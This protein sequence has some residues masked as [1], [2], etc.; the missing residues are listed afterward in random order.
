MPPLVCGVYRVFRD[1]HKF[2]IAWAVIC[3]ATV[4]VVNDLILLKIAPKSGLDYRAMLVNVP[5]A[6]SGRVVRP[7]DSDV[8]PIRIPI[9]PTLPLGGLEESD[10]RCGRCAPALHGVAV[11]LGRTEGRFT[12][13]R[14]IEVAPADGARLH[15]SLLL[16]FVD[17]SRHSYLLHCYVVSVAPSERKGKS[18]VPMVSN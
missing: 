15:P 10:P 4:L 5:R 13:L 1:R 2:K 12:A 14:D 9:S 7:A 8:P 17:A 6:R 16:P 3:T 18:N 11:T